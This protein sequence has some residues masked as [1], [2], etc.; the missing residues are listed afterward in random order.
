MHNAH[1]IIQQALAPFLGAALTQKAAATMKPR[2]QIETQVAGIP[3]LAQVLYF[4]RQA[5]WAGSAE[6]APSE[7]DY[8]GY[9]ECDFVIC[10]RRGRL[11]RW[12]EKK[13]TQKD[14]DRITQE[15]KEMMSN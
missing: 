14:T 1:P 13:M 2:S 5:P 8:Y 3:C 9:T 10:D 12:L 7:M 6:T 11:A 15:I 4:Y